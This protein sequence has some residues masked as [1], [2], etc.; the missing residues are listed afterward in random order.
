MLGRI[1]LATYRATAAVI[2]PETNRLMPNWRVDRRDFAVQAARFTFAQLKSPYPSR[3]D[4]QVW[5]MVG[6]T[7]TLGRDFRRQRPG[8]GGPVD[9]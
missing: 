4:A 1:S 7:P 8:T 6:V 9:R 3:T 2:A 5:R